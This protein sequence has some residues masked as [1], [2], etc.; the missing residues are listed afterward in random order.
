M[1]LEAVPPRNQLIHLRRSKSGS[2]LWCFAIN[3]CAFLLAPKCWAF[4]GAPAAHGDPGAPEA[5]G[6]TG[7]RRRCRWERLA[8]CGGAA[9]AATALC[10]TS[11][12]A[13]ALH[14]P[15][16]SDKAFPRGAIKRQSLVQPS[17]VD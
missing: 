14:H 3:F 5:S 8:G 11:P 7:G 15:Q 17:P 1:E 12:V 9:A 13:P 16:A 6:E 4:S 2:N 10:P